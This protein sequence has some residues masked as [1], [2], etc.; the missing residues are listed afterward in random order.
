MLERGDDRFDRACRDS[1]ADADTP[2]GW[3]IDRRVH[4]HD[5]ALLVERRPSGIALVDGRIDLQKA[6]IRAVADIVAL[7]E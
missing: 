2:A 7:G 1:E 4:A 3:P 6:V 5:L